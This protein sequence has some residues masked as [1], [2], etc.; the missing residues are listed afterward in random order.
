MR[1]VPLITRRT[2]LQGAAAL[3]FGAPYVVSATAM[4][5]GPRKSPAE[6]INIASIGVG[7]QG[8]GHLGGLVKNGDAQVVAICDVDAK[9]RTAGVNRAN[10]AY[11]EELKSASY[12]G[13]EGYNDFREVLARPDVDAVVIAVPDHWHAPIAIAAARAGK[14]IY[15]E[16]PMTLTIA[17][18]RAMVNAVRR[19]GRVFQTGSQRRSQSEIRHMCELV[20][21]GRLGR[22][23][24]VTATI[25][26]NNKTCPPTWS[27]EAVPQGFDYDMWLG[28]APWEPYTPLRCHYTFR[29]ILDY[30]GGQMTNWGAH[31]LDVAQWGIGADDS[32]PV[33]VE[34]RAEWPREGLFNTATK[35]DFTCTYANG[36]KLIGTT[37]PGHTRF[38]GDEGWISDGKE[39]MPRS[40]LQEPIG[41]GELHLYE[42]KGGHMGNF[43]ECVRTRRDPSAPVEVGHRSATVCHL[44]NIAMMLG[45]KVRWDP[46]AERFVNDPEADR[47][48]DRPRRAPWTI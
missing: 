44:G 42:A 28:P 15:C 6:R 20:R 13:C 21:N 33:E 39:A 36:V 18:G 1:K 46:V 3:A 38:E 24:T 2:F 30:S 41:P 23:R 14:D 47:M 25:A 5:A 19:C 16:K 48:L 32:G 4:G 22:L 9:Y 40:L 45:R 17:E 34:G 35:V 29:F 31:F 37:G 43:L 7:N 12:K 27:P 11:A 8:G 10:Q 26:T